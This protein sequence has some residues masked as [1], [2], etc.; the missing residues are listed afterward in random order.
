MI[1]NFTLI[2][3]LLDFEKEDTFYFIQVIKRRKENPDMP[4]GAQVINNYY[5]YSVDD[6]AKLYSKIVADCTLHNARAYINLNRL[7]AEKIAIHAAKKTLELVLQKDFKSVK[8][9]YAVVCGS[10]TSESTK[11]WVIDIDTHEEEE[12][13]NEI[14]TYIRELQIETKQPYTIIAEIPTK[15]GKHIISNPFNMKKFSDRYPTI[16]VHKNSPTILY[17]P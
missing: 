7:N 15:N 3:P 6:L 2:A 8:N 16:G 14:K 10:Y 4:T 13:Y 11:R 1:N 17:I 9:V 5:L 12:L